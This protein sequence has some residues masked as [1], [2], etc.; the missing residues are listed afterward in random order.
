M[1]DGAH[2]GSS[3]PGRIEMHTK[4]ATVG[5]GS[6][7]SKRYTITSHGD[8]QYEINE[9]GWTVNSY[10]LTGGTYEYQCRKRFST[11]SSA[12]TVDILRF[13]RHYW[14]SGSVRFD[15]RQT[16]YSSTEDNTFWLAGHGR[17][18]GSYS[19]NYSLSSIGNYNSSSGR[20]NLDNTGGSSS[21]G[22]STANYVDVR[23]YLP[24]YTHF[25]VTALVAHSTYY[26]DPSSMSDANSFAL[27]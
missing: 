15:V 5:P 6:G 22:N 3:A 17:N 18:D 2:S 13:K 14:G 25:Y 21:P 8:H 20:L 27:H 9:R 1:S 19:P 10:S 7:A 16:Y 24:A 26:T 12:A 11:G 4:P 23:L